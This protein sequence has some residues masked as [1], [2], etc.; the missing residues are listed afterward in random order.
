LAGEGTFWL[1]AGIAIAYVIQTAH[2]AWFFPAMLLII[3][4]RY[5]TFQT[6]YG[7]RIYW[8]LGVT[9]C[10]ASF[11]WAVLRAPASFAA[12]CGAAIEIIFAVLIFCQPKA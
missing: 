12:L 3:G 4:G 11:A 1:L 5:L 10:A 8:V 7:L 2:L 9:L 6:L